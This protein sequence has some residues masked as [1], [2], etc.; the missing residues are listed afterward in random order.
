MTDRLS[1]RG[2]V[3]ATITA[4]CS[5][6]GIVSIKEGVKAEPVHLM[7]LLAGLVIYGAGV[8][9][10]IILIGRYALSIAYPTVVG[11]SLVMLAAISFVILGEVMTPLKIVGA[12]LIVLGA[13]VLTK[14]ADRPPRGS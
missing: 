4:L 14:P 7:P 10:G 13:V 2:L 1:P 9:L 12:L 5:A 11:L 8:V 6:V 3:L